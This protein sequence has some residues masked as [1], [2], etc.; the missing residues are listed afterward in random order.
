MA[1]DDTSPNSIKPAAIQAIYQGKLSFPL[2]SIR[3]IG[4]TMDWSGGVT[5]SV[6]RAVA[7][8]LGKVWPAPAAD[9]QPSD[10]SSTPPLDN[11]RGNGALPMNQPENIS[12]SEN[13]SIW[14]T[15][16][17]PDCTLPL[18][19]SHLRNTGKVFSSHLGQPTYNYDTACAKVVFFDRAGAERALA[20]AGTFEIGGRRP[21]IRPNRIRK[22]AVAPSASSR[23]VQITGPSR[24]VNFRALSALFQAN[25]FYDLV[26]VHVTWQRGDAA[27]MVWE[28]GSYRCQAENAVKVVRAKK[29]SSKT[30]SGQPSPWDAVDFAWMPDPC[31]YTPPPAPGH[32]EHADANIR[33]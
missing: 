12:D 27:C 5:E 4:S 24:V 20:R 9:T 18:V 21:R 26:A 28:F 10:R 14:I 30:A 13:C 2:T 23:V 19:L 32:Q 25:F 15:N 17:P 31:A 3:S 1:H 33:P 29:H 8:K 11:Y 16:L 7:E 22:S 6:M